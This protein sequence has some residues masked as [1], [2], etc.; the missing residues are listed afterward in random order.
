M[1][2]RGFGA[3]VSGSSSLF[4]QPLIPRV[5]QL[6][7]GV[8]AGDTAED[9]AAQHRGG[10]HIVVVVQLPH[11]LACDIEAGDDTARSVDDLRVGAGLE[12]A[13]GEGDTPSDRIGQEGWGVEW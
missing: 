5:P 4:R 11:R 13:E 3:M 10:T 7:S 6:P 2:L 12:P 8:A 1:P 9:R